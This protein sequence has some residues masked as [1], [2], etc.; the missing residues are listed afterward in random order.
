MLTA[1]STIFARAA[2]IALAC[3]RCSIALAISGA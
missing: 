3:W 2:M 1:P